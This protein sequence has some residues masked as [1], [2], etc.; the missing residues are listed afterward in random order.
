MGVLLPEFT[1]VFKAAP[2]SPSL[3][4]KCTLSFGNTNIFQFDS[5]SPVCALLTFLLEENKLLDIGVFFR[6]YIFTPDPSIAFFFELYSP[7]LFLPYPFSC[8]RG[9]YK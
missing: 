7:I 4:M 9:V 6:D 5:L 2:T 8:I 1:V 3:V